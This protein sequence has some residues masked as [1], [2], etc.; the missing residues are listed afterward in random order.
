MFIGATKRRNANF[1]DEIGILK[2][3]FSSFESSDEN[4]NL[5]LLIQHYAREKKE[6]KGGDLRSF[7]RGLQ[8]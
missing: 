2:H 7:S 1:V 8:E 6:E 5:L 4:T 3:H